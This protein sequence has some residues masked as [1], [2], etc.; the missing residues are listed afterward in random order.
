LYIYDAFLLDTLLIT[1]TTDTSFEISQGFTGCCVWVDPKEELVYVFLSNRV[2]P[3]VKNWKSNTL[4]I[5][6]K[7]H[8]VVYDAIN[9][10]K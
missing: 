8:Q 5:R 6:Q 3:S 4:Q 1:S 2:H 7:V 9:D 10:R